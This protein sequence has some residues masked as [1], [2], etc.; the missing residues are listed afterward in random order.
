M[1]KLNPHLNVLLILTIVMFGCKPKTNSKDD[2]APKDMKQES[3]SK[4]T[5][6]TY[7]AGVKQ[8]NEW[9]FINAKG[10]Q[11]FNKKF[12]YIGKF[13]DGIYCV[14]QNG[15]RGQFSNAVLN[16]TYYAMDTNGNI[17]KSIKSDMPFTFSEGYAVVSEGGFKHVVDKKGTVIKTFEKPLGILNYSDGLLLVYTTD[18]KLN[19]YDTKGNEV[20]KG[21]SFGATA[22][23]EKGLT[24]AM[25]NKKYG[26]INKKGDL[27]LELK[28]DNLVI[29]NDYFFAKENGKWL[30]LDREFTTVLGPYD[31]I[32]YAGEKPFGILDKGEWK[33]VDEKGTPIT[34]ETFIE[35]DVF[36][37]GKAVVRKKDK[38]IGFIDAKGNFTK[39][40]G[41][42]ALALQNGLAIA[43]KNQKMGYVNKNAEWVI[44]PRYEVIQNFEKR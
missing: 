14:S 18:K 7:L 32:I 15:S 1:K 41:R 4:T 9:F 38:T 24:T 3:V 44:E 22:N 11:L 31:N 16:A 29:A 5:S 21:L 27:E 23:F 2:K 12:T 42:V 6:Y 19:Y 36:S 26:L 35:A 30:L 40:D 20:L 34:N 37:E 43:E 17:N 25:K 13:S 10:E 8:N 28:Y 33:F 39:L